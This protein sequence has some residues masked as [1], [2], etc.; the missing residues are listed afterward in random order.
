[1]I[2]NRPF[3]TTLQ[4]VEICILGDFGHVYPSRGACHTALKISTT[5]PSVFRMILGFKR[6]VHALVIR[7]GGSGYVALFEVGDDKTVIIGV[8]RHLREGDHH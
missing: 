4:Q 1:M 7:F 6:F 2:C 5:P 8:I 3:S